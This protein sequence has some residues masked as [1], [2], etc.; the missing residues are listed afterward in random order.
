MTC[1]QEKS[2]TNTHN[3]YVDL[4]EPNNEVLE[5]P[6]TR[7]DDLCFHIRIF[8]GPFSLDDEENEV[9]CLDLDPDDWEKNDFTPDIRRVLDENGYRLTSECAEDGDVLSFSCE[10]R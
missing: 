8:D 2:M 6:L 1:P 3:A 9:D 10:R 5:Y 7:G 4:M